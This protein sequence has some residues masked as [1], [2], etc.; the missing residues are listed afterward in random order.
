[1]IWEIGDRCQAPIRPG[2]RARRG[3]GSLAAALFRP[4]ATL[5]GMRGSAHGGRRRRRG[6]EG[7]EKPDKDLRSRS[8]VGAQH[9]GGGAG[10]G[11]ARG[12]PRRAA[13]G[14][15]VGRRGPRPGHPLRPGQARVESDR[16]QTGRRLVLD[17]PRRQPG[18]PGT[19]AHD[20]ERRLVLDRPLGQ[21]GLPPWLV[22]E[23]TGMQGRRARW[24]SVP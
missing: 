2:E 6:D 4:H 10:A 21:A 17:R 11:L 23:I 19:P 13:G 3:S 24:S 7:D 8:G 9:H 14:G 16:A 15:L 20:S 22:G 12:G 5:A 18:L 1:M